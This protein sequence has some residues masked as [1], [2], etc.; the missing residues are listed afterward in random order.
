MKLVK[1]LI[2]LLL[3]IGVFGTAAYFAY[4]LYLKPKQE[5][6]EAKAMP[7]EPPPP[8]P[9]PSLESV[10][11]AMKLYEN[12]QRE[13][14]ATLF[15]EIL[16]NYPGSSR[17]DE[18]KKIYGNMNADR[19]LSPAPGFDKIEYTV[20]RGDA[21]AKIANQHDSTAELIMRA[22]N[23]DSTLLQI[24][25]QL[26]VP[27]LNLSMVIDSATKRVTLLQDGK[28]FK[29]Y[30]STTWNVPGSAPTAP[31]SLRV[32]EKIAWHEGERVAF[33]SKEYIGSAR[34]IQISR[35]GVT[36]FSD[37]PGVTRPPSGI[38]IPP[39]EMEELHTLS[40]RNMEVELR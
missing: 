20:V 22:N 7:V 32:T 34:W 17:I 31:V 2:I 35:P 30:T 23:M 36:I 39:S 18:V 3:L 29:E 38:G 11:R 14:A 26:V 10:E 8:P 28:F 15:Q 21:L 5:L 9:D 12:N 1:A 24:G 25:Q 27:K 40:T 37:A 33:G 16:Q 13:E 19:I 4:D 6:V